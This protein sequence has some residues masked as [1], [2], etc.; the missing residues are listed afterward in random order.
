MSESTIPKIVHFIF[1]GTKSKEKQFNLIY[2]LSILSAYCVINPEKIFFWYEFEPYGYWWDKVKP[3]LELKKV[4]VPQKIGNKPILKIQHKADIIKLE[5]LLE[6]G[7]IYLDM[8]TICVKNIDELLNNNFVICKEKESG[9]CNCIMLANKDSSFLKEWY[10]NYGNV[11]EPYGWSEASVNYPL[12]LSL[13][14][15]DVTILPEENFLL[16]SW[17][18]VYKIF[19]GDFPLNNNLLILHLWETNSSKYYNFK[20]IEDILNS[21]FLYAKIVKY[22]YNTTNIKDL[23]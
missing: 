8:D 21:D 3:L 13:T 4:N 7:G 19:E 2:A 15:K 10:S 11:F 17:D 16:P 5:K 9:L 12:K 18:E 6:Y 14:N 23:I 22:L 20:K 1:I